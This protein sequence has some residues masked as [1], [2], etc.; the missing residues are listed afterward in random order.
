[1]TLS[2]TIIKATTKNTANA[3]KIIKD[4]IINYSCNSSLSLSAFFIASSL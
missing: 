2:G 1:M 3:P 4:T